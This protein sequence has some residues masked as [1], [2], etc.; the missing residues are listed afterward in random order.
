MASAHS[1]RRVS[2]SPLD[3][4]VA[5]IEDQVNHRQQGVQPFRQQIGGRHA[6]GDAGVADFIAGARQ[7]LR[8]G[9]LRDEEGARHLLGG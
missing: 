8:H 7:P 4:G 9:R 3:G 6:V 5:L 2:V 1:S